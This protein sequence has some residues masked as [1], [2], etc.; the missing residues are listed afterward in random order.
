MNGTPSGWGHHDSAYAKLAI[1]MNRT[2]SGWGHHALAFTKLAIQM[3]GTAPGWRI[4]ELPPQVVNWVFKWR[5]L[6][7]VGDIMSWL[8]KVGKHVIQR[9][10]T[11]PCWIYH[12]SACA[13][14]VI[15]MNGKLFEINNDI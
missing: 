10:G 8:R 6:L 11:A 14:L 5:G 12:D 15:L 4:Q 1:Q 2:R 9:N 3:N 7:P 13:K